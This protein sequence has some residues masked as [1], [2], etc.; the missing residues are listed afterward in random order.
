MECGE[1]VTGKA[2]RCEGRMGGRERVKADGVL[3]L[4][5]KFEQRM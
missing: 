5:M 2:G 3:R 4:D 1:G